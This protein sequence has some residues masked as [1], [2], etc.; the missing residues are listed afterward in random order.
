MVWVLLC[1]NTSKFFII[2]SSISIIT[3]WWLVTTSISLSRVTYAESKKFA[4]AH[5]ML[6]NFPKQFGTFQNYTKI[7]KHSLSKSSFQY[8]RCQAILRQKPQTRLY[9]HPI[10][11]NTT[12]C[13][14]IYI[15][16]E[17]LVQN[18][19]LST[20]YICTLNLKIDL[21]NPQFMATVHFLSTDPCQ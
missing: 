3:P 4:N 10:F 11:C 20:M 21:E 5:T 19:F 7:Y 1:A 14:F 17:Y 6:S 12:H 9:K 8:F 15:G 18:N 2:D 13:V 16:L